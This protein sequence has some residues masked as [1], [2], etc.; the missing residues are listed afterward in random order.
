MEQKIND[1]AHI[2]RGKLKSNAATEAGYAWE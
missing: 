2:E 1:E